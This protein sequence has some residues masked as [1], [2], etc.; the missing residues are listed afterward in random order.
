LAHVIAFIGT[1]AALLSAASLLRSH[2][3]LATFSHVR[4]QNHSMLGSRVCT[5]PE[6]FQQVG[7]HISFTI[8]C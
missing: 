2:C 4:P 6:R 1:S 5:K 7:M 8:V 3:I